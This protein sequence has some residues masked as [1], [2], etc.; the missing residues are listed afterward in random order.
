MSV[1]TV[2]K[3]VEALIYQCEFLGF[4]P[5]GTFS[6]SSLFVALALP[7]IVIASLNNGSSGFGDA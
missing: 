2:G 1:P 3:C 6:R 4:L 7:A 5:L